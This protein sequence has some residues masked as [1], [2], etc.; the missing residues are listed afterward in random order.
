MVFEDMDELFSVDP[1]KTNIDDDLTQVQYGL[2]PH[3][4]CATHILNLVASKDVDGFFSISSK[5]KTVYRNSFPKSSA[6]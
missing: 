5:S 4:R 3:S 1:E 6:L 2:P